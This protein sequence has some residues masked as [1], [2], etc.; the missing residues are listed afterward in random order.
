MLRRILYRFPPLNRLIWHNAHARA[1][2][3]RE[4]LRQLEAANRRLAAGLAGMR[5]VRFRL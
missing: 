4:R 2:E 3:K 1:N 5:R